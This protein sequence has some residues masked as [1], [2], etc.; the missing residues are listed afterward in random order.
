M[1]VTK[2]SF[3]TCKCGKENFLFTIENKNGCRA[4]VMNY[5]AILVNLW[6]PDR[7]GKLRDVVLGFDRLEDYYENDNFFGSTVGPN[8]NRIGGASFSLEG[9][10]YRLDANDGINNLHSHKQNGYHKR[11]WEARPGENSVAFF[12][13]DDNTLGFPGKKNV[14]VTYTLN[15]TNQLKICYHADSDRNT[16]LNL[17]NHSYF[18]LEG[19]RAG[20]IESHVLEL[21]ASR[22]TPVAEGGIPTGEIRAVEG[23]PFDF[24]SPK[25]IGE[26]INA[27]CGQLKRTGGYDHNWVLDGKNGTLRRFA[28]V[29]APTG[30]ITMNVYTELPG[31]QFYAGNFI[32]RQ[33]GKDNCIYDKRQ[34]F[35]L[36]TQYFPDSANRPEFPSAVFGPGRSYDSTTIYEFATDQ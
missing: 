13:E 7:E 35:C 10:V 9:K 11:Y 14:Q 33:N 23:T 15:D 21:S 16:L 17:T 20:N 3:G 30:G 32:D 28:R 29:T 4:S 36:E 24:R 1:A 2:N 22:F 26:D 27:D 25:T 12:L 18:N 6:I 31:V 19:H 8:A 34:G 5:G